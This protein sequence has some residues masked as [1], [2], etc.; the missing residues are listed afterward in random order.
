MSD[1]E[2]KKGFQE[3][4]PW[5]QR[6]GGPLLQRRLDAQRRE[7]AARGKARGSAPT[8]KATLTRVVGKAPEVVVKVGKP[9]RVGADGKRLY[10]TRQ[11]EA[12]RSGKFLEYIGRNS[13]I[14]IETSSGEV[15]TDHAG[16]RRLHREW[17]EHHDDA[18]E[19]GLAS[20]RT[21][22]YHS[23]VLSTPPGTDPARLM[24]AARAFAHSSFAGRHDYVLAL[25]TDTAH[26]H[27]NIGVRTV[28]YDGTKLHPS[29][30]DLH[31]WRVE[32]AAQLRRYGIEA[33]ATSRTTRAVILKPDR[34]SVR[35]IREREGT[36]AVDRAQVAEVARELQRHGELQERPWDRAI[37]ARR[38]QVVQG[39]VDAVSVLRKSADPADQALADR[40]E[41]YIKRLPP[42]ETRRHRIAA[43]VIPRLDELAAQQQDHDPRAPRPSPRR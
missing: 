7:R 40:T 24:E 43:A 35:H 8:D 4:W 27:V 36:A 28:G 20:G 13:K 6:R 38:Q 34:Q 23:L 19:Q 16:R 29:K 12:V 32:F 41:E 21:R 42:H 15:I 33:V 39:Y 11:G 10:A 30:D 31:G 22:L 3:E 37:T 1:F 5:M 2:E 9:K 25:H 14:D 18:I 26:P 17:S